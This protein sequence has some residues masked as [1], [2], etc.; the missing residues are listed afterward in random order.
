MQSLLEGYSCDVFISYRQNDNKSGWV[1]GFVSALRT[2]L[3]TLIKE[4][5]SVYFDTDP[6]EGLRETHLVDK[7]I[8]RRLRSLVLIPIISQTYCDPECFAWKNEFCSFLRQASQDRFGMDIDLRGGNVGSRILPVKIHDLDVTDSRILGDQLGHPPR[9]VDFVYR[10]PGMNRPLRPGEEVTP[11]GA[12]F[13]DQV[14]KMALAIKEIILSMQDRR[15]MAAGKRR[16]VDII[17][18]ARRS[19]NMMRSGIV[20][21]LAIAVLMLYKREQ[22]V[23]T[24]K[25]IAVLPFEDMSPARDQEWFSEGLSEEILNSLTRL[26]KLKV[27]S[28]T[29]SFYFKD[30]AVTISEIGEKLGVATVVE[31][32]VKRIGDQLRITAKLIRASDGFHIWTQDFNR[33]A[34]DLFKVQTEIA[35]SIASALALELSPEDISTIKL[36]TPTN[37]KA[38]EYYIKASHFHDRYRNA[39]KEEDFIT[40][41]AQFEQA[42]KI[43][44][45]YAVALAGLANLYDSYRTSNADPITLVRDSLARIAYRLNPRS[46]EVLGVMAYCYMNRVHPDFDSAF[47]CSKE[48]YRINPNDEWVNRNIG[49]FYTNVG[50]PDKALQYHQFASAQDPLSTTHMTELASIY[51][52]LGRREES[53]KVLK[54]VVELDSVNVNAMLLGGV[55]AMI[56]QDWAIMQRNAE[57]LKLSDAPLSDWS[58][59][60]IQALLSICRD[61]K[62]AET[63][64]A[65]CRV[66]YDKLLVYYAMGDKPGMVQSLELAIAQDPTISYQELTKSTMF[67]PIRGEELFIKL[68]SKLEVRDRKMREKYGVME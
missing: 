42:L 19:R 25:S 14:N 55:S 52:Y 21:L 24:E 3:A 37:P 57:R 51:L 43:D 6:H 31:G 62:S 63:A 39:F 40:S 27:M 5:V 26:K 12:R 47:F 66:P 13:E 46:T 34:D 53:I 49:F 1:S 41:K 15:E 9:F 36:E 10:S 58:A 16:G 35:E 23:V 56:N 61:H 48:M 2:E 33:P 4:P 22:P 65:L 18:Q 38:Y 68:V 28:R 17:A 32:S 59:K 64:F 8:E 20:T 30:K 54:R 11:G 7:S 50:L 60:F 44:P 29:S 67:E 45:E